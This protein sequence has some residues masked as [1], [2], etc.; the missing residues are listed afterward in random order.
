MRKL[1]T[2]K[3]QFIH[4]N[5]IS[6]NRFL[7]FHSFPSSC[8]LFQAFFS[9]FFFCSFNLLSVSFLLNLMPCLTN[10]SHVLASITQFPVSLKLKDHWTEK[11]LAFQIIISNMF[12]LLSLSIH[13]S[14]R[15]IPFP[16]KK[17]ITQRAWFLLFNI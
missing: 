8:V 11:L 10:S 15:S 6:F 4:Q 16:P 13:F 12:F 14:S 5:L 17:N 2:I 3:F 7:C 9:S 1:N